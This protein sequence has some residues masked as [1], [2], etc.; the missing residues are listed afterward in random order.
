LYPESV[1]IAV[2]A[3]H[4]VLPPFSVICPASASSVHR[5]PFC[6]SPAAIRANRSGFDDLR[7]LGALV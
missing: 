4:N 5:R 2:R 6:E 1:H 7:S 3:I